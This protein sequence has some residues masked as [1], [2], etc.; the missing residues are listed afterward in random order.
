[1]RNII[2][3]NNNNITSQILIIINKNCNIVTNVINNIYIILR[4]CE[5]HI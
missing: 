4:K 3:N 2:S 1:M 5:N